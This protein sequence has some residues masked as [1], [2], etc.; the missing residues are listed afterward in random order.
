MKKGKTIWCV[1]A[2]SGRVMGMYKTRR[3]IPDH[4]VELTG[5]RIARYGELKPRK[6]TKK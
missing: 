3:D 2:E 4:D 1:I 5:C 6:K